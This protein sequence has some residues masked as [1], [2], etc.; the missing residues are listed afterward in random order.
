MSVSPAALFVSLPA[1][2]VLLGLA[3]IC[4]REYRQ[5]QH[6]LAWCVVLDAIF[7]CFFHQGVTVEVSA[8]SWWIQVVNL[9]LRIMGIE[10]PDHMKYKQHRA[11]CVF[12]SVSVF[13]TRLINLYARVKLQ[14]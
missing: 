14:H 4:P 10:Q 12:T 8:N 13:K 7:V 11:P 6:T 9:E 5:I 3:A 2:E 1:N